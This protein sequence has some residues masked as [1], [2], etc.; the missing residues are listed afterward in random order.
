M[1]DDVLVAL[2]QEIE[3]RNMLVAYEIFL[4]RQ[5]ELNQLPSTPLL[6]DCLARLLDRTTDYKEMVVN[7][8][9]RLPASIEHTVEESMRLLLARGVVAL[10]E[11]R[12]QESM[13]RLE[14]VRALA[15]EHA[16]EGLR[17]VSRYYLAR[18]FYKSGNYHAALDTASEAR[19]ICGQK[20]PRILA[21]IEM[22]RAWVLFVQGSDEAEAALESAESVF[23]GGDYLEEANIASFRGRLLSHRA[24]HDDAIRLYREAIAHFE[25]GSAFQHPNL[26]RTYVHLAFSALSRARQIAKA[27]RT[28]GGND[29]GMSYRAEADTCLNLAAKMLPQNTGDR[30]ARLLYV[31]ALWCLDSGRPSACRTTLAEAES[32]CSQGA[33]LRAHIL[34]MRCRC[35]DYAGIS[36]AQRALQLAEQGGSRRLQARA[37]ACLGMCYLRNGSETAIAQ[38][39]LRKGRGDLT[40]TNLDYVRDEL[41]ELE[42]ELQAALR[43]NGIVVSTL[44]EQEVRNLGYQKSLDKVKREIVSHFLRNHG[45][46][47]SQVAVEL[48]SDSRTLR[49]ALGSAL[50]SSKQESEA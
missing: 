10:H 43:A 8:L 5:R 28:P 27:P 9:S 44:T 1:P 45:D 15:D 39:C 3:A 7:R 32:K 16:H 42:T 40:A 24:E 30:V 17:L 25:R 23:K 13:Q 41:D 14:V 18:A 26:A 50:G 21:L 22:V 46:S 34:I 35:N 37:R 12:Y 49:R 4:N 31:R 47:V 48:Q 38:E 6:V 11:E 33:V 29:Q 19:G 20:Q 36:E 2:A